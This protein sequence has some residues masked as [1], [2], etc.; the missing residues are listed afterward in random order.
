MYKNENTKSNATA[1]QKVMKIEVI[2]WINAV[3]LVLL[4]HRLLQTAFET[5][6][7]NK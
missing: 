5:E 1:S 4:R 7:L 3:E 6:N 2:R